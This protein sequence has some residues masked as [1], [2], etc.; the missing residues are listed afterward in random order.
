MPLTPNAAFIACN[1]KSNLARVLSLSE[2]RFVKDLNRASVGQA[3]RYVF[4]VDKT[5]E[6]WIGRY[7]RE[8]TAD[9]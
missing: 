2:E 5:H 3:E 8:G 9:K 7:L 4:C 1:D 6:K